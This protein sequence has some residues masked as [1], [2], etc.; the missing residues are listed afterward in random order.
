MRV[1]LDVARCQ[2]HARCLALAPS[3]FDI[4]DDGF[5]RVLIDGEVGTSDIEAAKSAVINC[6]E[7][8]ILIVE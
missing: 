2:G 8:A 4:D 3:L 6:P 5:G 7:G 1:E